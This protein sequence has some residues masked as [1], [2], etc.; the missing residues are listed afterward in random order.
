MLA[1]PSREMGKEDSLTYHSYHSTILTSNF[2][3]NF[4]GHV[5]TVSRD[6]SLCRHTSPLQASTRPLLISPRSPPSQFPQE[7]GTHREYLLQSIKRIRDMFCYHVRPPRSLHCEQ[8]AFRAKDSHSQSKNILRTCRWLWIV[9]CGGLAAF[10]VA[11]GIGAN[12]VANS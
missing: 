3:R 6:F 8:G 7:I 9:V 5:F 10:F 12:D 11:W 2:N 1:R 4:N